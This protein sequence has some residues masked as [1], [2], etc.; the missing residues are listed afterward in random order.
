MISQPVQSGRSFVN[1]F[2]IIFNIYFTPNKLLDLTTQSGE[3]LSQEEKGVY[4]SGKQL[5]KQCS[6]SD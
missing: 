6:E 4:C 1:D 3:I 5:L 2:I